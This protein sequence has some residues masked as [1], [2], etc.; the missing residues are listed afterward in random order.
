MPSAG[1]EPAI[2]AIDRPQ[3]YT[4][5]CTAT[6]IGNILRPIRNNSAGINLGVSV[7]ALAQNEYRVR[8]RQKV[9]YTR[10]ALFL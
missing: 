8:L 6:G 2:P 5:D 9:V 3:T 4:L 10:D 7:S 1:F